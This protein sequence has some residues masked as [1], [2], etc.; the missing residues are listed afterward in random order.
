MDVL[1][2]LT[3]SGMFPSSLWIRTIDVVPDAFIWMVNWL[4]YL[5]YEAVSSSSS[6]R[7]YLVQGMS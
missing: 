5:N 7:Y 6:N 2:N 1:N 3:G 4:H